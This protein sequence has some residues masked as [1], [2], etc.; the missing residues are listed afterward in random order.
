M[1]CTRV[2]SLEEMH[3]TIELLTRADDVGNAPNPR[4]DDL[5]SKQSHA[6][7]HFIIQME[8]GTG[9]APDP[10]RDDPG[11]SRSQVLLDLPSVKLGWY[12]GNAPS[13]P[14]SQ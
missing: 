5:F 6:L 7:A 9:N 11:S 14:H 3:S 13:R 8:E 12:E 4:R 2:S 10:R 1:I